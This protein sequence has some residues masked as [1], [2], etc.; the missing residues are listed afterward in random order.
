[1]SS[2]GMLSQKIEDYSQNHLNYLRNANMNNNTVN[3]I[4]YVNVNHSSGNG[5]IDSIINS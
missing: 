5:I 4:Q 2:D 1:M 3:N